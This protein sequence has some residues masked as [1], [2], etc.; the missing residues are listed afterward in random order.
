MHV[1]IS[2]IYVYVEV[3]YPTMRRP[4][5]SLVSS[6]GAP[7]ALATALEEEEVAGVFLLAADSEDFMGFFS[8]YCAVRI[9]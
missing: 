9:Q 1:Y 7:P 6:T 4:R 3:T 2:S 8:S 5:I